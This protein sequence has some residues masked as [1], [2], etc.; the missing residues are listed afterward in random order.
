MQS[1]VYFLGAND[2]YNSLKTTL[3]AEIDPEASCR[4]F[5]T[6][7]LGTYIS[8]FPHG[9]LVH[10]RFQASFDAPAWRIRGSEKL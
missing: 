1:L 4:S 5:R 7:A 9:V 10:G 6:H 2:P 8:S 3:K